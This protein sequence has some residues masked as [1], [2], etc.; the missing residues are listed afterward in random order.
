MLCGCV[1]P[2]QFELCN[3]RSSFSSIYYLAVVSDDNALEDRMRLG[4]N[5]MDDNWIKS[6]IDFNRWLM[7]NA[8]KTNPHIKLLN[9][10]KLTP[11]EAAEIADAWILE[12]MTNE[13]K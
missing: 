7:N 4:R 10:T 5:V 13:F 12:C 9:N 8:D 6:S 1:V 3:G 2:K 11:E